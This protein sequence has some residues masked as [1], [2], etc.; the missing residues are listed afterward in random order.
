[1]PLEK[2]LVLKNF[3]DVFSDDLPGLPLNKKI[4]FKI[5][6]IPDAV[7]ISKTPYKMAPVKLKESIINL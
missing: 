5:N 4:E 6:I 7:P 3:P 1:M 2:I